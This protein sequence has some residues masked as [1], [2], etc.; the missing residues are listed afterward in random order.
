MLCGQRFTGAAL[1][2]YMQLFDGAQR[3][4]LRYIVCR[5]CEDELLAGWVAKSLWRDGTGQ[6]NFWEE[7]T[8]AEDLYQLADATQVWGKPR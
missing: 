5:D 7:G 4:S 2:V 6:W 1:N 8:P 3:L